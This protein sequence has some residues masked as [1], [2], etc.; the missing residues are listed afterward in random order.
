MPQGGF[1]PAVLRARARIEKS[2]DGVGPGDLIKL[3]DAD[4]NEAISVVSNVRWVNRH[5]DYI[6]LADA[7][8]A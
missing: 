7:F 5:A 2:L 8:G 1:S 4:F 6:A 3:E